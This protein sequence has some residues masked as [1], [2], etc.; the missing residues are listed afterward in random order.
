M[1]LKIEPDRL[2]QL[3]NTVLIENELDA[4]V[5]EFTEKGVLFR[6]MSLQVVAVHALYTPDYFLDYESEKEEIP[7]PRTIL[8][9][10]GWGFKDKKLT[11][12]TEDS[13]LVIKGKKELYREPIIDMDRKKFKITIEEREHGWV[14]KGNPPFLAI[15]SA[16]DLK[17]PKADRYAFKCENGELT[18]SI[19]D[20]IGLYTKDLTP[21][22]VESSGDVEASFDGKHLPAILGILS[23]EIWCGLDEGAL[24]LSQNAKNHAVTLLLTSLEEE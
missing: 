5:G 17:L 15:F 11:L 9:H 3:L 8:N 2:R 12:Y 6:D 19:D 20:E 18:V 10:L 14:P 13:K 24:V 7:L 16:E 23:G 21:K 4:I 1:K 22:K